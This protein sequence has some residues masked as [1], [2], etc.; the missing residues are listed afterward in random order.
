MCFADYVSDDGVAWGKVQ[1]GGA[2]RETL[3][4]SL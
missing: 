2:A 1:F 3:K 4:S